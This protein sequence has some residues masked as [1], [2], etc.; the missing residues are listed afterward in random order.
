[1]SFAQ[2]AASTLPTLD[3]SAMELI[4][5]GSGSA[6]TLEAGN[7]QCNMLLVAENNEKLL[8]DCGSDLRFSLNAAGFQV[9]DLTDIYISHLHSDHVGGLEY[10]G[11]STRF[12][13]HCDRPRLYTSADIVQDL[14]DHTLAGGMRSLQGSP[15]TL[16]TFFQVQAIEPQGSFTWQGFRFQL[17]QVPHVHNGQGLMPSYGLWCDFHGTRVFFTTD[18]QFAWT[19]L[20]PYY[21]NADLIFQ[22]CETAPVPTS[23]HS[24]YEQ[25]LTLPPEVRAKTWLCGYQ[26]GSKPQAMVDGFRGFVKRGQVFRFTVNTVVTELRSI[27]LNL[28]VS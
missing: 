22:D 26:G 18:T 9:T 21:E 28:A 20:Q 2:T 25:L 10:V 17:V 15:A 23:V 5:L 27:G 24:R 13:P 12:N 6:F 19:T 14:W 7:F 4:F 16:D 3:R 1:M 11:F 8:L